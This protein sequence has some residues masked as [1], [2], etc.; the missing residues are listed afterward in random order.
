V[1][2]KGRTILVI[3]ERFAPCLALLNAIKQTDMVQISDA[4]LYTFK[5]TTDEEINGLP[6]LA[7]IRLFPN[8][9]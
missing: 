9:L 7:R 3:Q 5:T 8:P 1:P 2:G 6:R 4:L